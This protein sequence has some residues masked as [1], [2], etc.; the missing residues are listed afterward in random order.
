[1]TITVSLVGSDVSA[2]ADW[3]SYV[4]SHPDATTYHR[5]AWCTIFGEGLGYKC[6]L[7]LARNALGAPQGAL[8]LYLVN[9]PWRRRF[10]AV[11][12]RDRGGPLWDTNEALESLV[13]HAK[14]LARENRAQVMVLKSLR[15]FPEAVIQRQ[16]LVGSNYW[17]RSVMALGDLDEAG[18]WKRV[19]AKNR[20]MIRQGR[21]HGL[22]CRISTHAPDAASRWYMLHLTT[23]RR[24]GIPPFPRRFFET[25][26]RELER[27]GGVELL[28][29]T[30]QGKPCAATLLLLH[31]DTCIYG[32]SASTEEG[33]QWRANDLM[34]FEAMRL[35]LG[36]GKKYF[37][38][39]SDS[40]R[41]ES[42]LFFKRKWRAIQAPIPTYA[43]GP[44]LVITDSSQAR[45]GIARAVLRRLPLA[46]LDK[47]GRHLTRHL[48]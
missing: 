14:D 12:F 22:E 26:L 35:A 4:D 34:L 7:M 48:G 43:I 33:Q 27:V 11:P 37:D 38:L 40:P 42:L 1:M 13:R 29:V 24:L 25:M 2:Q 17:I 18:L 45:Y 31:G 21:E 41:Q 8:P 44:D 23:Q 3:D 36:Q 32:Y 46:F 15:P 16:G 28:E 47:V 19:G 5:R 39:G 20:N 9:S 10:V 6:F 30:H